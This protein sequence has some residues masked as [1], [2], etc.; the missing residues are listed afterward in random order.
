ME[1]MVCKEIREIQSTHLSGLCCN[2]ANWGRDLVTHLLEVTHGQWLCHNVQVHN[3]I[4][5]TL[6]TQR[7]EELQM[8][9]ECQQELGT[10]G[11]LEEDCYLAECNLGNLEEI[12]RM[13]ETY[14]LTS[15]QAT[16]EAGRLEG[17]RI[18]AEEASQ[19]TS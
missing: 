14:W 11:L 15:I 10:E 18:R 3:K 9:I 17:L 2:T 12:S 1:E 13:R 5:K 7:K 19:N 4:A 6:A 8:E 16:R